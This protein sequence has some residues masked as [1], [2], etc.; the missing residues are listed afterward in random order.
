MAKPILDLHCHTVESGHAYSTVK[1]NIEIASSKGIKF[2]GVSDHAPDMPGGGHPFY[3]QNM[4]VIPREVNGVK[5]L[6][7]IE[8]NIINFDGGIDVSDD[9]AKGTDYIIAS[10]HMPCIS[11]G[12]IKQNTKTILKVMDH[13]K[14]KIIGHPDDSQFPIDYKEIVKYAKEKNVLLEVNNSSM[15]TNSYRQ[16]AREN[17]AVILELCKEYGTRIILGSDA[18]ICY[19]VGDFSNAL[20][21]LKEVDFP[22]ELV[23]NYNEDEIIK[24]FGVDF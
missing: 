4:Y 15:N 21:L 5:V 13:E 17:G 14:V 1:E 19:S 2:L 18:H 3:F 16:R 11:P 12:D 8:A 20:D 22:D 23:I 9:I 10:F 7:G 24:F 6:R